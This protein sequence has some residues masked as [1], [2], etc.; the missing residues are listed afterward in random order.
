MGNMIKPLVV[1][2]VCVTSLGFTSV[3]AVDGIALKELAGL[4]KAVPEV[5]S[6]LSG[7]GHG[8]YYAN[9]YA[10]SIGQH[11]LYCQPRNNVMDADN[12]I[13]ILENEIKRGGHKPDET[14]ELIMLSGLRRT[15]PCPS[16]KSSPRMLK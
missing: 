7:I 8:Y 4:A 13:Q 11:K 9:A 15:F 10:D 12:Y 14:I 5:N 2:F 1:V 6:Y 3:K 16:D